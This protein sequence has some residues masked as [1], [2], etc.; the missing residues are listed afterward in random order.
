MD[1][2]LRIIE[3]TSELFD[4]LGIRSVTMD[5]IA[6]HLGISKKT[7][8]QYFAD[9]DALVNAV[10][11][12]NLNLFKTVCPAQTATSANAVEESV[13]AL[14]FM[15][16]HTKNLNPLFLYDLQKFHPIAYHKFL[17]FKENF[18]TQLIAKCLQ[19]GINEGFFREEIDIDIMAKYRMESSM[20]IFNMRLFPHTKYNLSKVNHQLFDLFLRGLLTSKGIT[21]Y[22]KLIKKYYDEKL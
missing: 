9:K 20:L 2:N 4:K 11:D 15:D 13:Q 1:I 12:Y 3:K 18:M 22:N 17:D 5:E 14:Q 7:I 16:E 10:L 6:L 8:Y 19:R 21:Q